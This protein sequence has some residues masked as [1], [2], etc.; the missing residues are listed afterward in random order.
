MPDPV[1]LTYMEYLELS[2]IAM[3]LKQRALL[4]PTKMTVDEM[5]DKFLALCAKLAGKFGN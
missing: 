4:Q 3:Q 2:E 5:A 1:Q